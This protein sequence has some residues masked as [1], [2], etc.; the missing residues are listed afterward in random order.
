MLRVGIGAFD[1]SLSNVSRI[2]IVIV[3]DNNSNRCACQAGDTPGTVQ[4]LLQS[5][6]RPGW[7]VYRP[8]GPDLGIGK[9]RDGQGAAT[10][11]QATPITTC[12]R[13]NEVLQIMHILLDMWE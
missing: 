2:N 13:S 3:F 5:P 4:T 6:D 12:D 9:A 11:W 7:I 10:S 8:A 1:L